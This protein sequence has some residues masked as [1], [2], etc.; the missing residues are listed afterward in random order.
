MLL[1]ALPGLKASRL[2]RTRICLRK[3]FLNIC[4][5]TQNFPSAP[6]SM[7]TPRTAPHSS[8]SAQR[9]RTAAR[10]SKTRARRLED[11]PGSGF[12]REFDPRHAVVTLNTG[13]AGLQQNKV[14]SLEDKPELNFMRAS[15]KACSY[16]GLAS[17]KH[18]RQNHAVKDVC[19]QLCTLC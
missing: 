5:R 19:S 8:C 10:E 1:P 3:L 2:C 4:P 13:L 16:R 17:K 11:K 9:G 12:N 15:F 6:C 18:V 14:R 7:C